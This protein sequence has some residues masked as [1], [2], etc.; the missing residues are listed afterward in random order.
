ML[1]QFHASYQRVEQSLQR[2]TD[3]I[4]AYNPSITASEELLAADESVNQNLE[5][6]ATHQSNYARIQ[7]L[8]KTTDSLD[9]TIKST[10]R[11]LAET[12]KQILAIPSSDPSDPRREVNIEELL[13][14]AK[15][16]GKTTVPPT[17]RKPLPDSLRPRAT[18]PAQ[19]ANGMATPPAGISQDP[20]AESQEEDKIENVAVKQLDAGSRAFID[21]MRDLPFE[22]WPSID[23]IQ[24]GGLAVIQRMVEE[25]KDPA[26]VLSAEEQAEEDA[27]K[28][29]EKEEEEAR[30]KEEMERR[31]MSSWGTGRAVAQNDVFNPDEA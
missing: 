19:I 8:R 2:L 28:Q 13:A 10:I 30:E 16:I 22:P 26:S 4:A 20:N 25:G 17:F 9:D 31:R 1:S 27:R 21:P 5:Q 7:E 15:F 14:Y 11:T 24:A 18:A 23:R 3:S 29:R 6:L 12:R